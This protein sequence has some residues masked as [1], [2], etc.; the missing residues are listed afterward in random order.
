MKKRW[1][2]FVLFLMVCFQTNACDVCGGAGTGAYLG[3][4]PQ[5]Q[6]NLI[7]L[8][9]QTQKF[10]TEATHAEEAADQ[11]QRYE[12][13]AAYYVA[14]KLQLLAIV[15]YQ[16]NQREEGS[17]ETD[18][19]GWGDIS[20]LGNYSFKPFVTGKKRWN[21]RFQ[22]G[23]GLVLPSGKYDEDAGRL[24]NFQLGRNSLDYLLSMQYYLAFGKWQL[25]QQF[26]YRLN[27]LH[28]D[29]YQ[30]GDEINEALRLSYRINWLD[31][32][33]IPFAGLSYEEAAYDLENS[34]R[35]ADTASNVLFLSL[36]NQWFKDNWTLGLEYRI[37]L[38][39]EIAEGQI[40]TKNRL[41]INL[42][43]LF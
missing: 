5:F 43:Y 23:A 28:K 41:T 38:S 22:L 18:L 20:V 6:R 15:P 25:N 34:K 2:V 42:A 7:G 17:L 31:A 32:K 33:W 10:V 29:D 1:L 39:Q 36:G 3:M 14:E 27:S 11:Y 8:R 16:F 26:T 37:P 13:L 4:M 24:R 19:S 40:E 12:L 35:K 9:M 30:Y 21:H